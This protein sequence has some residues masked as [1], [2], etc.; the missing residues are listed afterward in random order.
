MGICTIGGWFE[1]ATSLLLELENVSWI[2]KGRYILSD[3]WGS[4]VTFWGFCCGIK[5]TFWMS[6]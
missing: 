4:R 5:D 6:H 2:I 3:T 1:K